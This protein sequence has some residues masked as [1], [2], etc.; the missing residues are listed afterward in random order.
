MRF[1]VLD[2]RLEKAHDL[3]KNMKKPKEPTPEAGLKETDVIDVI[4]S[5]EDETVEPDGIVVSEPAW[6]MI[7][8][9]RPQDNPALV[10]LESLDS[11]E[12]KRTMK[13]ALKTFIWMFKKKPLNPKDDPE[14]W[15]YF[16]WE[17]VTYQ[18]LQ[19]ARARLA[20]SAFSPSHSNKILT[21]VKRVLKEAWRIGLIKERHYKL[22]QDV[23]R[24]KG[25]RV[26]KG[27][28]LL[29]EEVQELHAA[30]DASKAK[31]VRDWAIFVVF[32]AGGFRRTEVSRMN[33]E[34]IDRNG[35]SIT[36]IGKRNKERTVP[37]SSEA[38]KAIDAWLDVRGR[39]PG[40]LFTPMTKDGNVTMDRISPQTLYM[41]MD[42]LWR[43][44]EMEKFSPHDFRRTF[45]SE[46]IDQSGDIASVAKMVGHDDINTTKIYDLRDQK[47]QR[48]MVDARKMD[49]DKT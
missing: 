42:R 10:Y 28:M 48:K 47:A 18:Y 29:P 26:T 24:V 38:L 17:M 7:Q 27:R 45:I 34:S 1:R 19:T 31:G 43:R 30:C 23:G 4:D 12:S 25:V 36:V 49:G 2:T 13:V 32:W 41:F 21:A 20:A 44:L 37:I 39:E 35:P 40:P 15:M 6:E 22:V 5:P 8:A 11:E 9:R 14:P 33:I 46:M 16:P 3:E